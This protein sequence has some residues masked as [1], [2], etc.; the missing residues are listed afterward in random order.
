[1]VG[2]NTKSTPPAGLLEVDNFEKFAVVLR[3]IAWLWIVG[4]AVAYA[5][6]L[7]LASVLAAEL[8]G[9]VALELVGAA[10]IVVGPGSLGL[11]LSFVIERVSYLASDLNLF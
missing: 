11:A 2:V 3:A 9:I 10:A 1:M 4:A 6:Q 8:S 5:T 7:D